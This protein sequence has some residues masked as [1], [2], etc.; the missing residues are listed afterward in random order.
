M[1]I[2]KHTIWAPGALP[3]V[4]K[5]FRPIFR[6]LLPIVDFLCLVFSLAALGIG[7]RVVAENTTV[8]FAVLWGAAIGV[9][10]VTAF[11]GLVFQNDWLEILAKVGLCVSLAVYIGFLILSVGFGTYSTILTV[12]ITIGFLL[13]PLFRIF[14]L[15]GEIA[16]SGAR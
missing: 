13:F 14:D 1:D 9:S 6:V 3:L 10:A 4:Q 2:R 5:R 12:V 16:K 11:V 7:S 15:V 8:W